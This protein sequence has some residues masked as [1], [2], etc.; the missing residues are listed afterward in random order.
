MFGKSCQNNL[1]FEKKKKGADGMGG[2]VPA[3]LNLNISEFQP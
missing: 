3:A 2:H 1:F